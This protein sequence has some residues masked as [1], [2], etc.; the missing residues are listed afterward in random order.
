MA[1]LLAAVLLSGTLA[2]AYDNGLARTPQMGWVGEP[3]TPST[4]R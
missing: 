3:T 2:A 4:L 1:L